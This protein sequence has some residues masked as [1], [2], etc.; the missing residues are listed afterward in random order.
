MSSK[1]KIKNKLLNIGIVLICLITSIFLIANYKVKQFEETKQKI[2]LDSAMEFE[3]TNNLLNSSNKQELNKLYS[4]FDSYPYTEKEFFQDLKDFELFKRNLFAYYA[5]KMETIFLV[6][7]EKIDVFDVLFDPYFNQ[8]ALVEYGNFLNKNTLT[9]QLYSP[10]QYLKK[11]G[12][13]NYILDFHN[14][15]YGEDFRDPLWNRMNRIDNEER[16]ADII[17]SLKMYFLDKNIDLANI[18][19]MNKSNEAYMNAYL[20]TM[21]EKELTQLLDQGNEYID[22]SKVNDLISMYGEFKH[23]KKNYFEK[24]IQYEDQW[25]LMKSQRAALRYELK[26]IRVENDKLKNVISNT[27]QIKP[28]VSNMAF[29]QLTN[30]EH[31]FL[32]FIGLSATDNED[33]KVE[34][35][36]LND[37]NALIDIIFEKKVKNNS[38]DQ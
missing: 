28:V 14:Q 27:E 3:Y 13:I 6:K 30:F 34:R 20:I 35:L 10:E 15:K 22:D 4:F 11:Y 37:D 33:Q 25:L 26:K 31:Q 7:K 18:F 9:N 24:A 16:A 19:N 12:K 36:D 17:V 32:N 8:I 1:K 38:L 23:N 5:E 2:Y 29:Y 21:N